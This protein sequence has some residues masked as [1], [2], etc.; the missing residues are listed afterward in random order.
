MIMILYICIV[1]VFY[2]VGCFTLVTISLERYFAICRPLHSRKWQTLSHSYKILT[3]CWILSFLLNIPAAVHNRH[4]TYRYGNNVCR[5]IWD[6]IKLEKVYQI[7]LVVLLLIAPVVIM[8]TAY[9]LIAFTLWIGMKLDS[10]SEQG[11]TIMRIFF[12]KP[13][14]V[15]TYMYFKI[16]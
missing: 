4:I 12:S 15:M 8:T 6:N 16:S 7:L 13:L 14:I 5:E 10:Q 9:S 11:K 1:G 3:L 2:C